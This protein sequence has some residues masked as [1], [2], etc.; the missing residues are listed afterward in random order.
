MEEEDVHGLVGHGLFVV[1]SNACSVFQ[2][3]DDGGGDSRC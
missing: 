1:S 2:D 3:D